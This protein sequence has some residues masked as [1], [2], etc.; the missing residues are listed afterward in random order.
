MFNLFKD[1]SMGTS[2]STALEDSETVK[3]L[4]SLKTFDM[5]NKS[6][7]E[8]PFEEIRR[9]SNVLEILKLSNNKITKIDL[10]NKQNLVTFQKVSKNL[11]SL[12]LSNNPL[13]TI[14]KE[15]ENFSSLEELNLAQ[16]QISELPFLLNLKKLKKLDLFINKITNINLEPFTKLQNLELSFNF[17]SDINLENQ[18]SLKVLEMNSNK[19]IFILI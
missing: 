10:S 3:E 15:I 18:S 17:I 7:E 8:V 16:T 2:S 14:F 9:V 11:K 19:Y 5:S 13:K 6:M 4:D 1:Q 12:N